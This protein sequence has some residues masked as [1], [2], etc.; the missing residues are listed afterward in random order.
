MSDPLP[1]DPSLPLPGGTVLLEASAGT[2][3]THQIASLA[4][5]YVAEQD[6]PI[7]QVLLVTFGTAATK[8]L[9][10]RVFLRLSEVEAALS[11]AV[12]SG[13]PPSDAL[14]ARL[15]AHDATACRARLRRAL[16]GFERATIATTHTFCSMMLDRLGIA[17][18]WDR[19][20]RFTASLAQLATEAADDLYVGRYS[21]SPQPPFDLAFARK[22]ARFAVDH[23]DELFSGPDH[24]EEISFAEAVRAE[25][26][27][28][29]SRGRVYTYDDL[30][31]QMR[32]TLR[33]P[34]SG[35][36]ARGRLSEAFPVVLV[37][38]F[39]DTDPQ[40]WAI[41]RDAFLGAST[42]VLIG[43]P[44][45]SI[46]GF[47]NADLNC[48]L[49]ARATAGQHYTLPTNHR[50]DPGLVHAVNDLFEG[51]E[52]GHPQVRAFRVDPALSG[53]RLTAGGAGAGAAVRVR[54][55]NA[56]ATLSPSEAQA[57]IDSD[58]VS[59]VIGLLDNYEYQGVAL[60]ARDIAILVRN[61]RRAE[62]IV[63]ALRLAGI[64]S[65]FPGNEPV[66]A[67]AAAD[68]WLRVLEA[69]VGLSSPT[70]RAAA[71]TGLIGLETSELAADDGSQI[72]RIAE[73]LRA[74]ARL[75]HEG[76]I[77]S[78]WQGLRRL[79]EVDARLL[80]Q[81]G[82]QGHLVDLAQIAELLGAAQWNHRLTLSGCQTWLR[83]QIEGA[84]RGEDADA[85]RRIPHD[86][87]AVRIFT[88]HGSKGLQF[89]VVL[90]PSAA[91][92]EPFGQR[93]PFVF[94]D[95]S[96]RKLF[97]G[98]TSGRSSA[99]QRRLDEE[100]AEELRLLYVSMTRATSAV[101]AWWAP[102]A[103]TTDSPLHR[104][105]AR[106]SESRPRASYPLGALRGLPA[107]PWPQVG[108][109]PVPDTPAACLP[110]EPNPPPGPL[111]A[112]PFTRAIDQEWRRVSYSSLTANAHEVTDAPDDE[113]DL[114]ALEPF[115]EVPG[116][117]AALPLGELPG[118]VAFGSLA[119]LVLEY[120][121]WS[122]PDLEREVGEAVRAQLRRMPVP[123]VGVEAL[124][125]GLV[126]AL[127]TP[128][129]GLTER[130]LAEL[131]VQRRLA[132]L[133][134][135]LPLGRQATHTLADLAGLL[136]R[137]L[138]AGDPLSA[139]PDLLGSSAAAPESLRGVLT[140]SIDAVVEV[141]SRFVVLD[142]KT[143]R[144]P[145]A[146]P[147]QL[148]AGDYRPSA[149]ARA[150]MASHYP[151]QALLYSVALHRYLEWRLPG[152]SPER[153]L[154]GVGYLFVRAMIGP[155]TPLAESGRCGVFAWHP[156]PGLVIA[157]S[158]LLEGHRG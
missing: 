93:D 46:Y 18:D 84:H 140:G 38:E 64:P 137:E 41:L 121:D 71:L 154:G 139:Y 83:E 150:M 7:E 39:Q 22:I 102:T 78:G 72:A 111:A 97:V 87:D 106:G 81:P 63:E 128:L 25:V 15:Y 1:Y 51:V 36:V 109:E 90:L 130:A 13:A 49:E 134:F 54:M 58:L 136:G 80:Q 2:G 50:S 3:K 26:A 99:W 79:F 34:L 60:R 6:C 153:H 145:S 27:A 115:A 31:A 123:G 69:W 70:A 61:R 133:D 74:S 23:P 8:E 98:K 110:R 5:R 141:D 33:D 16:E 86:E 101:Y 85:P 21:G 126:A 127:R 24:Q 43:D 67:T 30:I 55:V 147:G 142:Y 19:S 92:W 56:A 135:D 28:R 122:S 20:A 44:K 132:E 62:S 118:G 11:L 155:R 151:L 57:R 65:S 116:L 107:R 59:Q 12:S 53:R 47:R 95:G 76:G 4:C 131:P 42:V 35:P 48:Y 17:A 82:G 52:F 104:L 68:D 152:Y 91:S 32:A 114:S 129:T 146:R 149:M 144:L 14:A 108:L 100:R 88:L 9:R 119:H 89:P 77:G 143:N 10:S 73:H 45:Q 29:K 37:D 103:T 120:V 156:T 66:F 112:R 148:T 158:Q 113:T 157:A 138:P 75:A 40:Q 94:T 124:T 125:T 117:D 96:T 105:L